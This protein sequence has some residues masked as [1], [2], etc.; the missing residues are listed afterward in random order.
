LDNFKRAVGERL[1]A[2]RIM[3]GFK[4]QAKLAKALGVDQSRV[5][6]WESGSNL[7][8]SNY[9]A[10]IHEVLGTDDDYLM[11]VS[12]EETL[13]SG[14]PLTLSRSAL[15]E[16]IEANYD[17]IPYGVVSQVVEQFVRAAPAIRASTLA[18]LLNDASLAE[19]YLPKN[20]KVQGTSK[21]R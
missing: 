2:R 18:V 9:R 12:V 1:R 7:P 4:T 10:K 15:K 20:A 19:P 3:L 17:E 5:A 13:R 16:L 6:R 21:K 8:D 14:Q 11:G